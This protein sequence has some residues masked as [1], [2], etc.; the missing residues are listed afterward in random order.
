MH[1]SHIVFVNTQVI[2][3]WASVPLSFH[4]IGHFLPKRLIYPTIFT[5]QKAEMVI[6]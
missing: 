6:D 5:G 4:A 3:D 2:G 1:M